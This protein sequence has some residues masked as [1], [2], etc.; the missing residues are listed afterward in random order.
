MN[1][2][3]ATTFYNWVFPIVRKLDVYQVFEKFKAWDE[4]QCGQKVEALQTHTALE[5]KKLSPILQ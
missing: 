1:F 5:F 4:C 2:V 3:D